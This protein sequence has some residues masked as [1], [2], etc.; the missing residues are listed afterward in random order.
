M[1]KRP[2]TRLLVATAIAV[3]TAG[4]A[5]TTRDAAAPDREKRVTRCVFP[6]VSSRHSHM[7]R[8]L[9]NAME[10]LRPEHG[11]FDMKSGYPREGWNDDPQTGLRL[12]RFTQLTAIGVWMELL[13]QVAAGYVDS[14]YLT[15]AEAL[16][17]LERVADSLLMDQRDPRISD[18][19]LLCNFIG[20]G[21]DGREA[22]LAS[23]ARKSDF[24]AAFGAVEGEAVWQAL[25]RHGWLKAWRGDDGAEILR[26]GKYG[27]GGFTGEIAAYDRPEIRDKIMAILDRKVLQ[28]IY[29][30]NANLSA[31]AAK[32]Q[33][34]LIDPA[35][36]DTV[37]A[38]RICQKLEFF[39]EAQRP[40]YEYLYDAQRGLFR[41]GWNA[42]D[43]RFVGWAV[44]E[45]EW[46][47]GYSDYLVNEFRGPTQFVLIRYGMP[48]A[49]L[50]NLGFWIKGRAMTGGGFLFTLAPWEGSAFQALGLSLFMRELTVPSW[51]AVLENAVRINLDYSRVGRLPGFLTE[52]YTGNGVEY[53]GKAGVPDLAVDQKPRVTNAPSL[54]TLGVA[55]SILPDEVEGFLA[56]RW[57]DVSS[58]FTR[59]GPWEGF[60][61]D[62]GTAVKCQTAVHVMSLILG[63]IGRGSETM[64]HYLVQR[65]LA[66]Q[67]DRIYPW[68]ERVDLLGSEAKA[69]VWSP[70]G[71]TI[72]G[73][74]IKGAYRLWGTGQDK[75]AI[76]WTF[77]GREDGVSVS[78]GELIVRY[79]NTGAAVA[80][81]LGFEDRESGSR[82]VANRIALR[83]EV[84]GA[85]EA[86]LRIP[87]P[88]TPGLTGIRE[89]VLIGSPESE[90]GIDVM[91]RDFRVVPFGSGT[92]IQP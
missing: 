89:V 16:A 38:G 61:V 83:F 71:G 63:G 8:L 49:A 56:E 67:W 36:R 14:P 4:C 68:G 12:R 37:T 43:R 69:V 35:V 87:L 26:E 34:A 55:Y 51:R 3:M 2:I 6:T 90:K 64:D 29:G 13:S 73:Q 86:E 75:G 31:S 10:Y 77:P 7:T 24:C 33:G 20:F 44:D 50:R 54:Y 28:I 15:R 19:G 53:T 42:S 57:R 22:P 65:G 58:L 47:A 41:F 81:T 66:G 76:T 25:K 52:S 85:T 32:A 48:M 27:D 74:A 11:L 60:R 62:S 70:G 30:D 92:Q 18:R 78:D 45:G 59:H 17:R 39:I 80:A 40:G 79:C 88:A 9:A 72:Q 46:N 91:F 1:V 21:L 82:S 23:V 84:T 5:T